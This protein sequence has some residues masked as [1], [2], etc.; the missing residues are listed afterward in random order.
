MG[1]FK[2]GVE[3]GDFLRINKKSH[4]EFP[5]VLKFPGGITYFGGIATYEIHFSPNF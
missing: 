4:I 1:I 3:R 5:G 2:W